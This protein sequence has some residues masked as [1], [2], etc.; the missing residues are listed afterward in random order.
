MIDTPNVP[1]PVVLRFPVTQDKNKR[2][3]ER[4]PDV[5]LL[6]KK[7]ERLERLRPGSRETVE[8]LVDEYLRQAFQKGGAR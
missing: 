2:R 6:M 7:L 8:E 1:R 4:H 3:S 5:V